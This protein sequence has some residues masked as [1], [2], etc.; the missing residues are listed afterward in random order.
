MTRSHGRRI[1]IAVFAALL[2]AA[3][4]VGAALGADAT[5][6]SGSATSFDATGAPLDQVS[7]PGSGGTMDDP[8]VVDLEGTVAWEGSTEVVLQ[9]GGW[10]VKTNS[11]TIASGDIGANE[12][13]TTAKSGTYNTAELPEITRYYLQ[14]KAIVPVSVEMNAPAGSCSGTVWITADQP[15]AFTPM[16]LTGLALMLLA[17]VLFW[18]IIFRTFVWVHPETGRLIETE[19]V[20][21]EY[22]EGYEAEHRVIASPPPDPGKGASS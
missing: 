6:C 15:P 14:G 19:Y 18:F 11:V 10:S 21:E 9:D 2:V 3:V 13:G 12:E 17:F 20:P 4:P 16:W 22:G 7:A 5:G 8:F 1:T